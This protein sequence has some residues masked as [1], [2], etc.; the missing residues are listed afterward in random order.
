MRISGEPDV[1]F[2]RGISKGPCAAS[3]S[4]GEHD[5]AIYQVV[6]A[7]YLMVLVPEIPDVDLNYANDR[8]LGWFLGP[9]SEPGTAI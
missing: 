2:R 9:C 4:F 8:L 6:N 3:I 1:A 7:C 5:S